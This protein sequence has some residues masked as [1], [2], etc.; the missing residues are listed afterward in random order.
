MALLRVITN[1]CIEGTRTPSLRGEVLGADTTGPAVARRYT[2]Y[3]RMVS[4]HKV[5][6]IRH[7]V[8]SRNQAKDIEISEIKGPRDREADSTVGLKAERLNLIIVLN[9]RQCNPLTSVCVVVLHTLNSSR[10]SSSVAHIVHPGV[11]TC[12]DKL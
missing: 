12:V 1:Y 2:I 5:H 10:S 9:R 3:Q 6:K 11:K 4:N 8:H 7:I